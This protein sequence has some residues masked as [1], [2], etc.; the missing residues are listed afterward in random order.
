MDQAPVVQQMALYFA[1][2]TLSEKAASE[3]TVQAFSNYN[4]NISLFKL[5]HEIAFI[6]AAQPLLFKYFKRNKKNKIQE[7][8]RRFLILNSQ[9]DINNWRSFVKKATSEDISMLI[10]Y[11]VF[12]FNESSIAESLEV[13]QGTVRLR[14]IKSL[15]L[16]GSLL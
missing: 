8:I 11:Y 13:S 12:Q 16:L 14:L 15:R 10:L 9:F 1:L 5:N 7:D 4:R 3:L 6:R 2:G